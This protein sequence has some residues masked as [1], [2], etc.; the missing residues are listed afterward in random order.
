ME[1]ENVS[2]IAVMLAPT[3]LVD[4]PS[5]A[6]LLASFAGNVDMPVV[7]AFVGG[8]DCRQ[9][10]DIL[11]RAGIPNYESPDRAM[12]ALSGMVQYTRM[13]ARRDEEPPVVVEGDKE[14]VRRLLDGIRAQDRAALSEDEGKQILRA[15]GIPVPVEIVA[16]DTKEAVE[17]ADRIGYPVVMKIASP[18]IAHKT[19]VGGVAVGVANAEEVKKQFSLI[20]SR[21]KNKMP[22]ARIDGVVIC[23]MMSG[24]EVII[25]MVRDPQFGPVITFGLGGIFVEI[26]KDVTQRIAPLTE[27]QVTKMISSIRAFPILSGA[28]GRKPADIKSLKNVI[29]R[30]AQISLDFP[31]ISELEINPVMVADEGKGCGAV[32]ALVTIRRENK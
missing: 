24:R 19:D 29:Y 11:R 21:S 1:D 16:K 31:E 8:K 27:A 22:D 12:R 9:G 32:D 20:V 10:I 26:M 6:D 17:A 2:C 3:D 13:N 28:R 18:D 25:G 7:A 5:T 30:V 14:R 23:Q 4:I 15:Y